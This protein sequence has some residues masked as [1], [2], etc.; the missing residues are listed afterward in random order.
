MGGDEIYG[1][2]SRC[3]AMSPAFPHACSH[4]PTLWSLAHVSMRMLG[5]DEGLPVDRF[6][7][8][9]FRCCSGGF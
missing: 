9:L 1:V 6:N 2:P 4:V 7:W 5:V 8:P 3:F